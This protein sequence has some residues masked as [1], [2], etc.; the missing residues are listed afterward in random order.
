[1]IYDARPVIEVFRRIG[2]AQMLGLRD[3]R[4]FDAP[5]FFALVRM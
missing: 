1:M 2:G 3:C 4:Y 5:L